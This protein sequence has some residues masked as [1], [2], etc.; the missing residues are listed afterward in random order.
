MSVKLHIFFVLVFVTASTVITADDQPFDLSA[1]ANKTYSDIWLD[2]DGGCYSEWFS[3][4]QQTFDGTPFSIGENVIRVAPGGTHDIESVGPLLAHGVAIL[5]AGRG[6]G[7]QILYL[8]IDVIGEDTST[9]VTV[10]VY[11]W[12]EGLTKNTGSQ[13]A[14]FSA[15]TERSIGQVC[16]S[17]AWFPGATGGITNIR[18]RN[19]R[20]LTDQQYVMVAA[21]TLLD[22]TPPTATPTVTPTN[23]PTA[24]PT[25]TPTS[26]PT[27]TATPTPTP[28]T[29]PTPTATPIPED[30][31]IMTMGAY[32]VEGFDPP[33]LVDYGA[34]PMDN[35]FTDATDGKGLIV[36]LQ[37]GQG[38]FL[39]AGQMLPAGEDRLVE[40]STSVRATS[41][42]VQLALVAFAS[43]ADG[44]YAY[45]NPTN[46][47]VPVGKWGEMRLVYDSPTD[48]I[49]PALQ[50]VLPSDSASETETVYV[51]NLDVEP[52]W[53]SGRS[54]VEMVADTSFDTINKLLLGLNPNS[55]LPMGETP[56]TVS[57]CWD[58]RV[59][60][61][62]IC[63][64]VIRRISRSPHGI[65]FSLTGS[66]P[67]C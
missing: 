60:S 19:E 51:D 25:Y 36:T 17:R 33:V 15:Q 24:T 59:R 55:F 14:K 44:S 40:L 42:S 45:V 26:T 50:F 64:T 53:I 13:V 48:E 22:I 32:P 34:V 46:R 66:L 18:I 56:G 4:E 31:L 9:T 6:L 39:L 16:L 5:A 11:E 54:P 27:H 58:V 20:A 62:R 8:K 7:N 37:P 12:S 52:C 23:T 57:Q 30:Y 29:T 3:A 38:G 1:A 43:T 49:I 2:L 21:L 61:K 67:V 63:S 10:P 47:E 35:A 41:N 65:S 28:T